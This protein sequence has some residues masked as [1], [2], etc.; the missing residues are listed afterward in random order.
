MLGAFQGTAAFDD[1]TTL[2]ISPLEPYA[3]TVG[4][5]ETKWVTPK[6]IDFQKGREKMEEWRRRKVAEVI[7]VGIRSGRGCWGEGVLCEGRG[8]RGRNGG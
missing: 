8:V 6:D 2:G 3:T 4:M 5:E 1:G 7:P